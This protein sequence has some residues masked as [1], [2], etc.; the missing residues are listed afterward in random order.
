MYGVEQDERIKGASS[1]IYDMILR[2]GERE[3]L[4]GTTMVQNRCPGAST[5]TQRKYQGTRTRSESRSSSSPWISA[6]KPVLRLDPVA[7]ERRRSENRQL[8]SAPAS[9]LP[10][11]RGVPMS[12]MGVSVPRQVRRRGDDVVVAKEQP[13]LCSQSSA[14]DS[15]PRQHPAGAGRRAS[16]R[17][18]KVTEGVRRSEAV[19][20]STPSSTTV[21]TSWRLARMVECEPSRGASCAGRQATAGTS[22]RLSRR[23][24][25]TP[26][27][28][29][30]AAVC[31]ISETV[32]HCS[33][34]GR[35]GRGRRPAGLPAPSRPRRRGIVRRRPRRRRPEPALDH[36]PRTRRSADHQRGRD[37]RRCAQRRD[38]QLRSLRER[39]LE[40][41]HSVLEHGDTEVLAHLA[42]DHD[43]CRWRA[44]WTACL[45]SRS[46]TPARAAVLGR[47]RMGKKPLYYWL[48]ADTF[49]FASEIKGVLAHPA[50]PCQLDHARYRPI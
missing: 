36:R 27:S 28:V 26:R 16:A 14:P 5:S 31:G 39:L 3:V 48:G 25:R 34:G 19:V 40:D 45:R 35:R 41:G 49:V 6:R 43:A 22:A 32:Y 29:A 33:P 20:S 4:V 2:T 9:N 21:S 50:V 46:G 47:D 1:Q 23:L 18:T 7:P 44:N 12:G 24:D 8:H 38:L 11:T 15:E 17:N 30:S 37:D 13:G 10:A 42:E